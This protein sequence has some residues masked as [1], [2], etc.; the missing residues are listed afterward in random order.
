[1]KI[2][3]RAMCYDEIKNISSEFP[4]SWNSKTKF[5]TQSIDFINN[6]VKDGEFSNSKFKNDKYEYVVKYVLL[7]LD[8]FVK[9]SDN[10]Y[11]LYR[12]NE[13]LTKVI[14]IFKL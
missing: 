1:M 5:F 3:Y 12:K 10:E 7:D 13:P 2:L 14:E 9:I 11:M 8:G 6:R 4:F